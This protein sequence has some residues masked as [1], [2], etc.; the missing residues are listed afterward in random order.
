MRNVAIIGPGRV[1]TLLA[2]A[3]SR[4][5]LRVVAIGGGRASAREQLARTV[6]GSRVH[7]TLQAAAA[8]ADLVVLCVPDDALEAVATD[9]AVHGAVGPDQRVVHVSGVRGC[10]PLHR[11]A[12]TGAHVAACHPA[13]TV[14][15][16]ETDPE[17]LIGVAWAVT[18][19]APDQVWAR[20]LVVLLGGDPFPVPED[21][22][23]LY[24]AGLTVAANAVGAAV[25]TARRL[26][27]AAHVDAP[28]AFLSPLIAASVTNVLSAGAQALTG[29]IVR[30]DLGTVRSHLAVIDR[31]APELSEAYRALGRATLSPIRPTMDPELAAQFAHLLR[32]DRI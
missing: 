26:L 29:P 5:G 11:I 31:D 12:L 6:A 24:H 23:A 27:L 28:E 2:V 22:R 21:A 32:E 30:G 18:A 7:D 25:A 3:F 9:L 15:A 13:M 17:A 4:A 10:A 1:G 19:A 8:A 16:G 14:P 20:D